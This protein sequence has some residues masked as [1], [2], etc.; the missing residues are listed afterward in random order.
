MLPKI[1]HSF[2]KFHGKKDVNCSLKE[3]KEIKNL[4]WK[5][6]KKKKKKNENT[7][8]RAEL[9]FLERGFSLRNWR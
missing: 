2:K 8:Y 7:G 5:K 9:A 4:H 3:I 6:R 1:K